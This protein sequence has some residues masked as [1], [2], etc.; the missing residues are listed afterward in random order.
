MNENHQLLSN[1]NRNVIEKFNIETPEII[2]IDDFLFARSKMYA[3]KCGD[4]SK[5]NSKGL[6]ISYYKTSKFEEYKKCL[7]SREYQKECHNYVIRSLNHGMYHRK[8][9]NLPYLHLVINDVNKVILKVNLG[10]T[11]INC[12]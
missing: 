5:N 12:L 3:F 8:L 10:I 6:C 4:D 1:K 9:K 7:D 11:T 2:W